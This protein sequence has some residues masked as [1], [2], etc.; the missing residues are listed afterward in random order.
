MFWN[1]SGISWVRPVQGIGVKLDDKLIKVNIEGIPNIYEINEIQD[2][3]IQ[4]FED[5]LHRDL[6]GYEYDT[7]ST[8][9]QAQVL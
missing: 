3:E 9:L 6:H 2:I 8:N 1:N 4:I 5:F 7:K